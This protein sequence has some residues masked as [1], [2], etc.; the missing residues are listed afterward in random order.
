MY[1]P[2]A[3]W[4]EEGA[5]QV[6]LEVTASALPAAAPAE[7]ALDALASAHGLTAREAEVAVLL[8]RRLRND[9][10]ART[11]GVS[12]H[13]ARRHT[14]RVFQ[15]LGVRSRGDVAAVVHAGIGA[16]AS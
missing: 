6:A 3:L 9:E 7:R 15:K 1:A 4:G 5:V 14:E 12:A 2:S 11:L 10:V 16:V 8:A 13:T